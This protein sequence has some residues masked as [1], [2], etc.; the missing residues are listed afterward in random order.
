MVQ[1]VSPSFTRRGTGSSSK[2][3]RDLDPSLLPLKQVVANT[4]ADRGVDALV[5]DYLSALLTHLTTTLTQNLGREILPSTLDIVLAVP[6][7]WSDAAKARTGQICEAASRSP[8][9]LVSE[10]EAAATYAIRELDPRGLGVDDTI[11]VVDAGGGTVDLTSYTVS[12]LGPL[13]VE[14]AAPATGALCGAA[15][16]DMRF[17]KYLRAK[18]GGA[19]GFDE[20]VLAGAVEHFESE[21][22]S[23]RVFCKG[24]LRLNMLGQT[25]VH[26]SRTR[27]PGIPL[28]RPR[29]P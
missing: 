22:S 15:F 17:A 10:P 9:R 24:S 8:V 20:G 1:A 5:A 3:T 27:K 26:D 11:V 13:R 28:P 14:E 25:P 23:W 2:R 6:A 21:V 4:T 12:S 18:L 29:P 16:L 7:I 19:E